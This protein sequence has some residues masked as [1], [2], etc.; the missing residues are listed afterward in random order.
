M[1]F[2]APLFLAIMVMLY[3]IF[4]VQAD[5]AASDAARAQSSNVGGTLL[6]YRNYV[7]DYALANPGAVG[8]VADAALALPTW[9]RKDA[10]I[11]NYVIAGRSFVYYVPVG[12][13]MSLADLLY[14]SEEGASLQMGIARGGM[15]HSPNAGNTGIGL[16]GAIPEG[17]IVLAL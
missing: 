2:L 11:G 9:F 17:S 4:A 16:P 1:P 7:S 13:R 3:G 8:P 6:A 15:L 10:R 14:N 5:R 12:Q